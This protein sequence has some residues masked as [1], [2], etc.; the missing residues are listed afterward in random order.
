MAGLVDFRKDLPSVIGYLPKSY[1][2]KPNK[3]ANLMFKALMVNRGK[4]EFSG[5]RI[6]VH[7]K[8]DVK[9]LMKFELSNPI[10]SLLAITATPRYLNLDGQLHNLEILQRL[11]KH[12]YIKRL[13]S[14]EIEFISPY[15]GNKGKAKGKL[16]CID[17]E[18]LE[19]EPICLSTI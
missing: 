15:T 2:F 19:D 18:S 17:A 10:G 3:T 8:P 4:Y 5:D 12:L 11:T 16:Y 7:E 6:I 13:G 14:E 1:L 9:S